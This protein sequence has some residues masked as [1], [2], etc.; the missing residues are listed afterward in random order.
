MCPGAVLGQVGDAV[1]VVVPTRVRHTVLG[2]PGIGEAI[3]VAVGGGR[4]GRADAYRTGRVTSLRAA[5]RVG[6]HGVDVVHAGC[7]P[8]H[9]PVIE[10]ARGGEAGG[11]QRLRGRV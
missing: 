1:A 3:A 7:E 8:G 11:D 4:N 9:V 2:F 6:D 5:G 10:A